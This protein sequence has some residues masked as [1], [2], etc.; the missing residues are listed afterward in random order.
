MMSAQARSGRAAAP[1]FV[2]PKLLFFVE[3]IGVTT[4]GQGQT[5]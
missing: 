5:N 4:I 1:V 2:V 3:K